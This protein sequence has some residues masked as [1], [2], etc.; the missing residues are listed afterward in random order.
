[1]SP[2]TFTY[3]Q[4]MNKKRSFVRISFSPRP[5]FHVQM[6]C[7]ADVT[8]HQSITTLSPTSLAAPYE[9]VNR[10]TERNRIRTAKTMNY[11]RY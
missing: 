8:K 10:I 7:T 1:M 2:P 3:S 6:L 5:K 11:T 9:C 4:H